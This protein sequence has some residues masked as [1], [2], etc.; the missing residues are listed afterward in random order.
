[1]KHKIFWKEVRRSIQHSLG[2][3]L[4]I[5]GIVALGAGFLAGL[6]ATE[7]V[8]R[9]TG[10]QYFTD[11][12]YMDIKIQSTLGLTEDDVEALR[13]VKG[14][15]QVQP[16]YMLDLITTV[17]GMEGEKVVRFSGMPEKM[18]Q[19]VLLDGRLPEAEGECVV[20]PG[21]VSASGVQ[22]GD[23]LTVLE[24]GLQRREYKVAFQA[25]DGS[26]AA[27]YESMYSNSW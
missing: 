2:R 3:F 23:T 26:M 19:L 22:V 1:M 16:S 10:D 4:A 7:P 5:L 18:N 8:M 9:R 24:D 17:S 15:R 12:N 13:Q 20:N 27:A 25:I 6:S 21:R 14:V 11:T